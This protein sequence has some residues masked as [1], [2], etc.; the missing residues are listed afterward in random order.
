[1]E[2]TRMNKIKFR[3]TCCKQI[4]KMNRTVPDG[5][6]D[7][8]YN[9]ISW[10][11]FGENVPRLSK[12]IWICSDRIPEI[13]QM[14]TIQVAKPFEEKIGSEFNV[15]FRPTS[16]LYNGWGEYPEDIDKCAVVRCRFEKIL[17][18]NKY[19]A[20]IRVK[21]IRVTPLSEIHRTYEPVFTDDDLEIFAGVTE[22]DTTECHTDKWEAKYWTA[23][24]DTGE[25]KLMY[26]DDN[27]QRHLIL[28]E[29]YN[30]HDDIAYIG[31]IIRK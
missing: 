9:N 26:I 27:N 8:A 20:Y 23:Q 6:A 14:R 24:S 7:W 12:N 30:F 15:M 21:V 19:K 10:S 3:C 31:N 11:D 5:F 22:C 16:I 29:Y 13:N 1:M 28:M 17:S 4:V 2:I 18:I 25:N